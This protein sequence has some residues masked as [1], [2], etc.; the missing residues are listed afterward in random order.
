MASGTSTADRAL[1]LKALYEAPEIVRLVN[2][3]DAISA[4]VVADLPG[5][6][7]I[8]TAGHSIAASFGY[9]DGGMPLDL[10]LAGAR[11]IAEAVDLPVTADLDDGYDEP[12]ETIRRAIGFGIVGANVEDRMRPL[13]E[14][15]VPR[16]RDHP[17][18]RAG[19]RRLPAERP[20]RRHDRARRAHTS[21]S[22]SR[23]RSS[24]GRRT[25]TR[26]RRSCSCRERSGA[27][28][29]ERLVDGLGRGRISLL[30]LPGALPAAEYEALGVARISYGPLPQRVALRALRDLAT[31]LYADGVIPRTPPPQL[32]RPALRRIRDDLQ[33]DPPSAVLQS[34]RV[35]RRR[36]TAIVRSVLI[37]TT[38][39]LPGWTI[40]EV[41]GE[42]FGLTVRSRN[43]VATFG[44]SLQSLL[45]GEVSG[46]TQALADS[47]YQV[48]ERMVQ[49]AEA[50][51]GNAV[52]AMRFDT[53]EMGQT[54]TEICAYG[55]AVRAHKNL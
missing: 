21:T 29:V 50:K 49:E 22:G 9:P 3:W 54:W 55:T 30:G 41:L 10:A 2:V 27:S 45:G 23:R 34:A 16:A 8:A 25:S 44:S 46:M 39:E 33:D 40:D 52:V 48:I 20:H 15:V 17:R 43:L 53:S 1:Q 32:G 14:A 5:T 6:T 19:R 7:V 38:N 11:T 37:A 13:D 28:V 47:R 35:L 42:V 31:D 12:G 18:R 24:A 36:S 26:A 4:K 51:G